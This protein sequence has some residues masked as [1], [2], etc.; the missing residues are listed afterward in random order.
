MFVHT[1]NSIKA[2]CHEN[3]DHYAKGFCYQCYKVD[4]RKRNPRLIETARIRGNRYIIKHPNQSRLSHRFRR[5]GITKDIYYKMLEAQYW[6]CRICLSP[7]KDDKRTHIDHDHSTNKVRSL[8]CGNCN[9][10]LGLLKDSKFL[11]SRAKAYLEHFG[12]EIAIEN[13]R[14]VDLPKRLK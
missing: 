6:C 2:N 13:V 11:L 12:D 10:G 5:Y 3:R 8:L 1:K 9:S 7:I 14:Y 4:L